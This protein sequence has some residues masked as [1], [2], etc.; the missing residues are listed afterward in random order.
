MWMGYNYTI[1]AHPRVDSYTETLQFRTKA[2]IEFW[3]CLLLA[4]PFLLPDGASRAG[5]S[6]STSYVQNEGSENVIG[7]D[8]PLGHQGRLLRRHLA[9]CCSASLSVLLRAD[10]VPVRRGS[11]RTRSSLQIGHAELEV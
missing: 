5:R 2:W 10:R 7:L 3:G 1:N 6:C 11:R 9:A 4:L 8:L